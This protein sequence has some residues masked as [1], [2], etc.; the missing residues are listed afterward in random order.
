ME[1]VKRRG[2]ETSENTKEKRKFEL[3]VQKTGYRRT[4]KSETGREEIE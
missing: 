2:E 4:K 3:K 1:N